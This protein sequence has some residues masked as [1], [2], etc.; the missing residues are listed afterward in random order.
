[1]VHT[2][3]PCGGIDF[4]YNLYPSIFIPPVSHPEQ[5]FDRT[6]AAVDEFSSGVGKTSIE[7]PGEVWERPKVEV[8]KGSE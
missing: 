1:L 5:I 3:H 8:V 4:Y 2:V 6:K 7:K